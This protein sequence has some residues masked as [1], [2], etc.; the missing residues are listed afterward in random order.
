M[1]TSASASSDPDDNNALSILAINASFT[2]F[3]L[4][5]VVLRLYV[6]S[7]MLKTTGPEDYAIGAAMVHSPYAPYIMQN[8]FVDR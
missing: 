7:I 4:L 3:A 5:A 2:G 8:I 6:R 1:S